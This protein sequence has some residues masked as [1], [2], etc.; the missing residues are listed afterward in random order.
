MPEGTVA[1]I[2]GASSGI[3]AAAARRLARERGARVILVARREERLRE[4]AGA[5]G[6]GATWVAAELV[7]DDA[8]ERIASH[9]RHLHDGPLT[10]LVNNPGAAWRARFADGG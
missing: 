4:L 3:G 9:V 6:T 5:L 8:P 2:T 1:L 10:L 7:S